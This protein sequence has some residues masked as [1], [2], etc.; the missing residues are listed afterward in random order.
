[1]RSVQ[2]I[3][4]N[5]FME[6][7][8]W[9]AGFSD[10]TVLHNLLHVNGVESLHCMMPFNFNEHAHGRSMESVFTLL[11]GSGVTY[12][13]V[14]HPY[15]RE[16]EAKGLI[17]GGNLS[18]LYSLRGTPLDLDYK[19]KI[20]F[21]EDVDEYLYHLDRMMM[22]LTISG[23]LENIAGLIVGGMTGFNDN[24]IPFGKD[25]YEIITDAV[26]EYDFPVI[27]NFPS[28]HQTDNMGIILGREV[29]MKVT[30]KD[31]DVKFSGFDS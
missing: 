31:V 3:S 9:I 22:N 5:K 26:K 28:G 15:N 19:G 16:G 27:F 12:P 8:K 7:P 30:G 24:I 1:M 17:T 13:I 18:V 29:F 23:I 14:S 21:I 20:L 10:I 11:S 2:G 6:S 25:P 4:L